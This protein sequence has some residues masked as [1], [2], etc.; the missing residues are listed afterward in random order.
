MTNPEPQTAQAPAAES[1]G[2]YADR[3][4][5][6]ADLRRHTARGTIV[7]AIYQIALAALSALRG[8]VAAIFLT[9][10]EYGV[11]GLL[12]LAL[13]TVVGMKQI[14]VNEKYIQQSEQDQVLAFQRA[15]TV[16][17]LFSAV[18][19]PA[20][21][22]LILAFAAITGHPE[23]VGPGIV[24]A[25]AVPAGALQ[26]PVW[27]FYRR[28]DFRR[29][30]I[31]QG[32]E[33][34]IAT[35]VTIALAALGAGYWS[36]VVGAVVGAWAA[37]AAA[38]RFSPFPFALRFD[39]GTL[40]QYFGFSAPLVV[41]GLATLAAFQVIYLFGNEAIGL[42]ALGAFTVAGNLVQ[43]TDRADSIITE[44]LYPALCAVQDRIEVLLEA[45]VKSNRLALIWAAPFG[46]GVSLFA[47]DL[48]RFGLGERWSDVV[49]VLEILGVVTAVHHIGFNWHAFYRARGV[50][51]PIA[52]VAVATS[53]AVVAAAIPLM[54]EF[55]VVGLGW[56]FACGEA[57]GLALR[58]G[59]VSRLFGGFRPF[60]QLLRTVCPAAIAALAV[61]AART[62]GL[63]D[64]SLAAALAQLAGFLAITAALTWI[65]ERPLLQEAFGYLGLR[66]RRGGRPAGAYSYSDPRTLTR[67]RR[68]TRSSSR[69]NPAS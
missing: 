23:L 38:L 33:P 19:I 21:A 20:V 52:F 4:G 6:I 59:F 57:V 18:L 63:D 69:G 44:T 47:A 54:S 34:V 7:N 51:W 8:L 28:M 64:A 3:F 15:F 14:G 30:R 13:W 42:A 50:T 58:V 16:E 68:G 36:L 10:S 11:W 55:G 43:F 39:P 49:G 9:Q 65:L 45:F 46:I 29:Q 2:P 25:L 66:L 27:A 5:E 37:A 12:G 1:A 35:A 22:A 48:V 41:G 62:A 31:L 61:L 32:T 60:P 40:R 53:I 24:L 67:P 17:I 56:A 26:F